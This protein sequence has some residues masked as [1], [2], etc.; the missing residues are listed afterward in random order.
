MC[1][2]AWLW[3][4][5]GFVPYVYAPYVLAF[6]VVFEGNLRGSGDD[7]CVGADQASGPH[8]PRRLAGAGER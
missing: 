6:D 1:A 4:F 5:V 3:L 8:V 2:R 7:V